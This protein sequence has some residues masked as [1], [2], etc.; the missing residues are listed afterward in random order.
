MWFNKLGSFSEIRVWNL[1]SKLENRL[2]SNNNPE[3][4]QIRQFIG[5][6]SLESA[7][8]GTQTVINAHEFHD[9]SISPD[10]TKLDQVNFQF[11]QKMADLCQKLNVARIIQV[12]SIY[13]QCSTMW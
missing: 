11:V 2:N 8:D 6:D 10:K 3:D 9:L 13:L 12:S 4:D 7:L 1:E 5:L